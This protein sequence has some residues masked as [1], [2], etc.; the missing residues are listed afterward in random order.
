MNS[1]RHLNWC[2]SQTFRIAALPSLLEMA[3]TDVVPQRR[4]WDMVCILGSPV[5][6]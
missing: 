2:Q 5:I 1:T 3:D 4:L 6:P